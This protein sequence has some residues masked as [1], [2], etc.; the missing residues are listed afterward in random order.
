[1]GANKKES[2]VK[3]K[4]IKINEDNCNGCGLCVPNCAE[5]ALQII[6]GKVRL[7]SD[8]FCDGL[9]ACI[10][11]CSN[12]AIAIEEREAEPYDEKKV[13]EYIVKCGPNV[14]KAHLEHLKDHNETCYFNEAVD[15]LKNNNIPIP[16]LTDSGTQQCGCPGAKAMTIDRDDYEADETGKRQ[17]QL[18]QWPVQFHLINPKASYF[19]HKD[20]LLAADCV[21]YTYADFHKDYLNGKSLIIGC[22]KL[23]SEQEV[24]SAKL[25]TLID[26]AQINT[27]TVMIMEVPCC[28]G[29]LMLARQAVQAAERKI[30][31]KLIIVGIEGDILSQEWI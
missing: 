19:H 27:L 17:S 25:I 11:H 8:I 6:D 10:G 16:A 5:G 22:P 3:R 1:M 4:I 9:G 14:I 29:L 28:G 12:D 13:M 30:P 23:D 31:I 18:R 21:A 7:I 26:E 15:Y 2:C 24:Y 20:V